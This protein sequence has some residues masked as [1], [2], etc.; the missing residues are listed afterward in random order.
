MTAVM[1]TMTG[2]GS[3]KTTDTVMKRTIHTLCMGIAS[4]LILSACTGDRQKQITIYLVGDSTMADKPDPEN[5]P[6][7]GWGQLLPSFFTDQVSVQ[8][9]AVNGRS[10]KSFIDE[11]KWH[12]VISQVQPGDYVFI[13]FGHNDQKEYDPNR[14]V[15]P[16]S[17][18]RRNLEMMVRETIENGGNPILLSSIVR[19]NF[20]EE[21]TL[22]DTHG[23][24]P[25]VARGVASNNGVP[26]IDLQQMTEDLVTGLGPEGSKYL[27]M[28]LRPGEFAMYPEG[29]T[30]NTHL[31]VKGA[32]EVAGMV[33]RSIRDQGV[34]LS[35][36]LEPSKMKPRIL[37]VVGGHSYDTTEFHQMLG[38]M[39]DFHF[40][41]ISHPFAENFMRSEYV[42]SYDGILFYDFIP[43][44]PLKDS[45]I[46]LNLAR[47]GMPMLFLHHS[48]ATF[49]AWDGYTDLVGGKY[50]TEPEGND[51]AGLSDYRHD[52]DLEI[53]VLDRKH[54]VTRDMDD[55][56]I[57]DEGYSKLR[58]REGITPLLA[59]EH[60]DCSEV[61]GW[62]NH[63]DH[64]TTVWLLFGH[65]KQAYENP[66]FRQLTENA[67][68]WLTDGSPD[69]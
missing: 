5:N 13:Q 10:S 56:T 47:R 38:S 46:Y 40:D 21:G 54:P 33:A 57:H 43:G 44:L 58:I 2:S 18:Y 3:N 24:Y 61:V 48:I 17:A 7:R 31:Q 37:A 65:D 29:R 32:T 69:R 34:P 39:D 50:V 67:L 12:R 45:S 64:S 15:N 66:A 25:Y 8:N 51:S 1:P 53:R 60:P 35:A 59:T 20:N 19:R 23:P 9:H 14:Y 6:E 68:T 27:Y 28:I 26:F 55:F 30:D 52:L 16:Y 4:L 62:V 42:H 22:V 63:F 41:S 49:Q 36:Y 11:G